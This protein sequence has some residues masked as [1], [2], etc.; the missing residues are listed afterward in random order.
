MGEVRDPASGLVAELKRE[1][2]FLNERQRV[3]LLQ[4]LREDLASID[5]GEVKTQQLH[6]SMGEAVA[7]LERVADHLEL[8]ADAR[9]AMTCVS[10]IER[11]Q[12]CGK[13]GMLGRSAERCGAHGN[14]PSPLLSSR[15]SCRSAF[16]VVGNASKKLA[17][18][19]EGPCSPS[20]LFRTG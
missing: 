20:A 13:A 2:A 5:H 3:E 11:R 18:A 10:S 12:P 15:R 8:D 9:L 16:S 14:S 4:W 6:V 19:G 1:I 7:A 17:A